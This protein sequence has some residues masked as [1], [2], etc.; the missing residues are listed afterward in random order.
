[1]PTDLRHRTHRQVQRISVDHLQDDVLG[2][3]EHQTSIAPFHHLAGEERVASDVQRR[4]TL[5][6]EII[7]SGALRCQ[8]QDDV[9]VGRV[10]A[11]EISKVQVGVGV[12]EGVGLHLEA[13][14]TV[15]GVLWRFSCVELCVAAE[16]DALQ[17]TT[18]GGA[19]AAAVVLHRRQHL[20]SLLL[21]RKK[22]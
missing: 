4:E 5:L 7:T 6:A 11:V 1:M 19:V 20:V 13:Q 8:H 22:V 21:P 18:D 12:E 9:V 2:V 17:F 14:A 15:G 3:V 16:E 10:H